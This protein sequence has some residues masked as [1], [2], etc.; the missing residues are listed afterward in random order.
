MADTWPKIREN[1]IAKRTRQYIS[2]RRVVAF[3]WGALFWGYSGYSYSG[4]EI[5]E[6][7]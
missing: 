7:T 3:S 1:R 2:V 5:T 6:C 4:L